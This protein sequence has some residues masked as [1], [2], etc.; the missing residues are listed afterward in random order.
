[1]RILIISTFF[2]PV[3]FGG[4]EVECSGVV[5]RLREAHEVQVLT[6][7]GGSA[8]A[9]EPGVRRALP[10]LTPDPR[11]ALRAPAAAMTGARIARELLRSPPDL[12]YVW[13]GSEI[14]QS[15]LRIIADAALP[16]AVRVCEHWFA[17]L[18]TADQFLR[19]LIPGRRAAPRAAWAT[20]CRAVNRHPSLRLEPLAPVRLAISWNS[21]AIR[22]MAPAPAFVDIVLEETQHSVPRWG[23]LFD[24]VVRR[25]GPGRE[26]V[27]V[28][29]VTPYKGVDVAIE[30]L[31]RLRSG[32]VADARLTVIGPEDGDH[33]DQLRRRAQEL[34][35]G[36]AITWLGPQTPTATA[37][38]LAGAAA[39]IVPSVWDEPFPLVTIEGALA[40]VA[41][42]ASDV[43][44]VAEG[45]RDEEHALLFARRDADGAAR[46]LARVFTEPQASAER[47]RRAYAHAQR[48]RLAP[49]LD[50]QVAFVTRAHRAL[51]RAR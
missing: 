14:P 50:E 20:V 26:I 49:Y 41:V 13:N 33:G 44:G 4:Y 45:L 25:P 42:V 30:A 10:Y 2:P 32:P 38:A 24:G 23:D 28:G 15:V 51:T 6:S 43:G 22:R 11:G 7:A 47:V 35:V 5:E 1:M 46:A 34:G 39:L 27:F 8:A 21:A 3:A 48:Y 12:V 19:E 9:P 29:R 40:R 17:Q 36:S 37:D 31:A 18:F 16:M